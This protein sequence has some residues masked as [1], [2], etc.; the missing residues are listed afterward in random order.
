MSG[1]SRTVST[2][3]PV[4]RVFPAAFAGRPE[5]FALANAEAA[6]W[7]AAMHTLAFMF[8][9]HPRAS[10]GPRQPAAQSDECILAFHIFGE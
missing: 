1:V 7:R 4:A 9:E 6:R 10:H 8:C 3:H 2:P 5:A